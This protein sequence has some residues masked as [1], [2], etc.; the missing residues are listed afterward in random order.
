[1]EGGGRKGAVRKACE[2]VGGGDIS[3]ISLSF[4]LSLS[5]LLSLS[6]YIYFL[7][8]L[9]TFLYIIFSPAFLYL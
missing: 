7:L 5:P 8:L 3:L 6:L 2:W 4:S 9:E 1:M